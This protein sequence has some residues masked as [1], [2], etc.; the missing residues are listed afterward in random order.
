M[1]KITARAFL[2]TAANEYRKDS[3]QD[4][5]CNHICI[6]TNASCPPTKFELGLPV[7]CCLFLSQPLPLTGTALRNSQTAVSQSTALQGCSSAPLSGTNL[8]FQVLMLNWVI[9]SG[10]ALWQSLQLMCSLMRFCCHWECSSKGKHN[11]PPS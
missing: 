11:E 2:S 6:F 10:Q 3:Y 4:T 1:Y 5:P 9:S 8:T 7:L